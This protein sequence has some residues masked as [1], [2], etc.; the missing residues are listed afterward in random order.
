MRRIHMCLSVRGALAQP[1][2]VLKEWVGAFKTNGRPCT[3]VRDVRENLIEALAE[4]YEY[5]PSEGC[6]NFDPK[7]G[8]LGHPVEE[9]TDQ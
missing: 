7:R 8:C 5:I 2:H 4:G 3:C 9:A 6:D 1:D